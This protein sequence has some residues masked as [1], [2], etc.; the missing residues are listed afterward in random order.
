MLT[1]NTTATDRESE[2]RTISDINY[3]PEEI[4]PER[5]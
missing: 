4:K 3:S 1:Y 5:H 2:I